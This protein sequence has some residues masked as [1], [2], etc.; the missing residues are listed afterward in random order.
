M[1]FKD[2]FK[3][4]LTIILL[5]SL[6]FSQVQSQGIELAAYAGYTFADRLNFTD[7]GWGLIGDGFTYGGTI[8]KKISKSNLV[9]LL[10]TRQNVICEYEAYDYYTG[11]SISGYNIQVSVNYMQVGFCRLIQLGTSENREGF[12][13]IDLGAVLFSPAEDY[14]DKWMF[15]AGFKLGVKIWASKK[16]GFLLESDLQLPVQGAGI[17]IFEGND[18]ANTGVSTVTAITQF[19]FKGGLILKLNK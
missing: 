18:G 14:K 6:F 15:A 7:G 9:E 19:G 13:G 16:V 5:N 11:G 8:S 1:L 12:A 17:G 4:V 3:L 2:I 10:Y